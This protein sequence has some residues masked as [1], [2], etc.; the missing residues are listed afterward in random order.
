M[1]NAALNAAPYCFR[2]PI[3]IL[4]F[5]QAS[6]NAKLGPQRPADLVGQHSGK[7]ERSKKKAVQACRTFSGSQLLP[8]HEADVLL[9]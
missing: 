3:G 1:A 8:N 9:P 2:A 4:S 6:I 5:D 7:A